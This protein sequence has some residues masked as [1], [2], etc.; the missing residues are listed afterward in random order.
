MQLS[1][2]QLTSTAHQFGELAP[3]VLSPLLEQSSSPQLSSKASL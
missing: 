3:L 1:S 2:P